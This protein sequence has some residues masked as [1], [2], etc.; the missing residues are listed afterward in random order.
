[1]SKTFTEKLRKKYLTACDKNKG[2][3]EYYHCASSTKIIPRILNLKHDYV[4]C[5][6]KHETKTGKKNEILE[7]KLA[8]F[9]VKKASEDENWLLPIKFKEWRLLDAERNFAD[10]DISEENKGKGKRLDILAYE[11]KTKSYIIL[12]L[13]I[14]RA[15][16]KADEELKC[17]TNTIKKWID[18]ANNV[19]SVNAENIKGYIVW[20]APNGERKKIENQW[21][22]IEYDIEFLKNDVEKLEFSIKTEP[23]L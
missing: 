19:Y 3:E 14:S 16:T 4:F 18:D 7:Y 1:M 12:E 22:I 6:K 20:N 17:Y 13:K 5:D 15:L 10:A 21:G 9:L 11:E 2:Q 8:A 23:K